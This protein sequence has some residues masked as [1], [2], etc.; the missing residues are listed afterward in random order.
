MKQVSGAAYIP[1]RG[2]RAALAAALAALV[3]IAAFSASASAQS[4]VAGNASWIWYVDHSGGSAQ[5]IAKQA[6]RS[7]LDAV[8][9]KSADGTSP[10]SQFTPELVS[11]LH[12]RGLSVCG[13]QFVYGRNAAA[14]ARVGAQAA[15]AGADC[16]IIDAESDLE[17]QYAAADTYMRK[18]RALVGAD[19]P[20]GLSSFPY[21]DYHPAFPYSVFLGPGGADFN[22][23][24]VYWHT[25]G[26][27]VVNSLTHTYVFNRPYDVPLFPVGQTYADPPR[28]D[29]KAFRRYSRDFGAEGVSWWSWQ[30]TSK[31]EWKAIHKRVGRGAKGFDPDQS[32]PELGPGDAGDLVVWAQELLAG[33][34][35]SLAVNGKYNGRTERAVENVQAVQGLPVTGEIDDRTWKRLLDSRP[36][37]VRWAAPRTASGARVGA[38]REP[39]SASLPAIGPEIPPALSGAG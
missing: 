15:E 33:A 20:L 25:I 32:Y 29:L 36:V 21:V 38:E 3:L 5:A 7:G 14:E 11:A 31:R 6:K 24:Q 39:A 8:F 23:P 19:Y 16:L 10:W 1:G 17:G 13:W 2:R 27:P 35:E 37:P 18:L 4:P 22:L 34:G 26:D 30:E 28:R 12:A 9:I